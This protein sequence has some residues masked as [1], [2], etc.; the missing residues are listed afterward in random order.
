MESQIC[1][2]PHPPTAELEVGAGCS[3]KERWPLPAFLSGRKLPPFSS[4]PFA[5]LFISS[6]CVSGAF[7]SAAPGWTSEKVSLSKSMGGPLRG[8][9]WDSRCPL[10]PLAHCSLQPE[11]IATILPGTGGRSVG[12]G[13]LIFQGG[14]LQWRF[15]PVFICHM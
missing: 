13:T 14:P 2:Y 9:A 8:T 6:P 5:G 10:S 15:F 3:T 11:V 1:S 12:L 7:Q 4:R